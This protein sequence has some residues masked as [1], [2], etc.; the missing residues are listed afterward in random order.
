MWQQVVVVLVVLGAAWVAFWRLA[1]SAWLFRLLNR[2]QHWLPEEGFLGRRI[3]RKRA[4]LT[5][6]GC[7]N[8]T[9]KVP[10]SAG[11]KPL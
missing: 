9:A 6:A 5:A 2:M 3:A 8:C 1:P 7:G 11:G 10:P 4:K